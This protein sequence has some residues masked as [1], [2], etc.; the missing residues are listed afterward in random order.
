MEEKGEKVCEAARLGDV[1]G[2][3]SLIDAGYDVTYFD[4][5]GLTPLMLVVVPSFS[6]DYFIILPRISNLIHNLGYGVTCFR[7]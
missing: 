6:L 4:A 7:V 3:T 1:A 2:I 5:D